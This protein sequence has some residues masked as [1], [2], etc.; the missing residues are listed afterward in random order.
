MNATLEAPGGEAGG[1]LDGSRSPGRL[2]GG[3]LRPMLTLVRR[4][5][6]EHRSL[7]IAPLVVA[8]LLLIGALFGLPNFD[9]RSV[10]I[11]PEQLRMAF[12]IGLWGLNLSQYL[13]MSIILWFYASDCLY[14]ER[15]D[16]SILFWKSMPVSDARTVLSKLLVAMVV[17]P[18]GVFLVGAVTSLVFCAIW[19][20]RALAGTLPPL[21]WDTLTWLRF[22]G[23]TL[24]ASVI[25]A[26]WYA[27]VT[28]YLLLVSAWARRNVQLWL[29]LPPIVALLLE[30]RLLGTAH[31]STILWYRLGGLWP[32][33]LIASIGAL[34]SGPGA[35]PDPA[36]PFFSGFNMAAAFGNIDL[37]L[38]LLAAAAFVFGAI[39]I[40]RYR[41][42]T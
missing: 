14:S 37:W 16:R 17:E 27:P 19:S 15:R 35:G 30:N 7:W 5:Y 32:P 9:V 18:L 40:R 11:P 31:L 21:H 24:L 22:E 6:W 34:F 41:D 1:A 38:G 3:P 29:L 33:R 4:E 2:V 20:A 39:R 28:A 25:G 8:A 42:D 13:T 23:F 36:E 12:A 10:D 26:L